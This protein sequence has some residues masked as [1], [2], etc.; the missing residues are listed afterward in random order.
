LACGVT[1]RSLN[2]K[3]RPHFC[4]TYVPASMLIPGLRNP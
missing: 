2:A 3:V 1:P 4:I